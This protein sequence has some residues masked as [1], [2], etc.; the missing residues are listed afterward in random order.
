MI[1][2]V[3]ELLINSIPATVLS[4]DEVDLHNKSKKGQNKTRETVLSKN[5]FLARFN[6]NMLRDQR[7]KRNMSSLQHVTRGGI[8]SQE[9]IE[10][11]WLRSR[12][13]GFLD[14]IFLY[15]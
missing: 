5:S 4:L 14:K 10:M 11:K 1:E 2:K 8:H 13:P 15:S 6:Q 3:E 9:M 7:M 12:N